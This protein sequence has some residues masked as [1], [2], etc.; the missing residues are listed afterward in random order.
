[1]IKQDFQW[2][3]EAENYIENGGKI[4]FES[5]LEDVKATFA[6]M[7]GDEKEETLTN[8]EVSSVEEYAERLYESIEKVNKN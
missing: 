2:D 4:D 6:D 8:C 7:A 1:M 5:V 3:E